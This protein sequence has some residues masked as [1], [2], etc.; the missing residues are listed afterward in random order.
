MCISTVLCLLLLVS[1]GNK[2][3]N[4]ASFMSSLLLAVPMVILHSYYIALQTYV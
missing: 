2:T 4:F 1:K 3:N